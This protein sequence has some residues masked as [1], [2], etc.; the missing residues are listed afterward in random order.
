MKKLTT[1]DRQEQALRA[2]NR[3]IACMVA[4]P[5][6]PEHLGG[7]VYFAALALHR[8]AQSDPDGAAATWAAK[9]LEDARSNK[10]GIVAVPTREQT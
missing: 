2:L 8:M 10:T 6:S 7:A 9:Y 1:V 4:W 3:A 5:P